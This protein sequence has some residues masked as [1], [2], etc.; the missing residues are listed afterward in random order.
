MLQIME[1]ERKIFVAWLKKFIKIDKI[2]TGKY[3]AEKVGC[4]PTTISS[5]IRNR[6]KPDLAM[7]TAIL[8]AS[9]VTYGEML[10]IGRDELKKSGQS[11]NIDADSDNVLTFKTK[12]E[13]EHFK[14]IQTF[15]DPD[16]ALQF[17]SFLSKLEKLDVRKYEEIFGRVRGIVRELES[18][19]RPPEGT[20][21]SG[22]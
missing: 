19:R 6:T 14:I 4:D 17:N 16:T 12:I 8:D 9:G 22:E 21:T 18:Q 15:D 3:L 13:Q 10:K 1:D 2:K 11:P 7:R 20:G 5:Y